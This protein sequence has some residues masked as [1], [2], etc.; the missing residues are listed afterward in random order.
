MTK[1]IKQAALE[2]VRLQKRA[3]CPKCF[4]TPQEN[5]HMISYNVYKLI[6]LISIMGLFIALG[7]AAV[8]DKSQSRW[9]APFHGIALLLILTAGFGMLARL[10]VHG[11]LPGWVIGKL[12][13]WLLLGGALAIARKKLLPAPAFVLLLIALGGVAASMAL[14]KP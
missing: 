6:H 14:W 5:L 11:A 8:T 2:L 12:V 1:R 13:I 10:G 4:L 7:S 3:Y 9:A